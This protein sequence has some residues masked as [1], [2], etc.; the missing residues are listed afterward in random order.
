MKSKRTRVSA[1]IDDNAV[2]R[3]VVENIQPIVDHGK[4]PIKRT[5]DEVVH[6]TADI[7]ADGHDVIKALLLHRRQEE[8]W[9]ET[10]MKPAENDVFAATFSVQDLGHY[11]YTVE[12]WIDRFESWLQDILKKIRLEWT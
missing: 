9:Q 12:A 3:V 1:V 4:F 2:L 11:E 8:N 6:V 7:F 10:P 5:P